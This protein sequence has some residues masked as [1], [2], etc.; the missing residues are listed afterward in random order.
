M[1]SGMI[2][3]MSLNI[4]Y[5]GDGFDPWQRRIGLVK[6]AVLAAS[7]DILALQAVRQEPA[8]YAGIHQA[9]QLA[10]LLP[11]YQT[12]VFQP[13][14]PQPDGSVNGSSILYESGYTFVE[15]GRLSKRIDYAWLNQELA[16]SLRSIAVIA[17]ESA[18]D[19][20]RVSDHAGLQVTLAW[21]AELLLRVL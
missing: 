21:P 1:R 4:N 13:A 14:D 2:R 11:D 3:I 5:Y 6:E 18:P 12:V 8:R 15:E 9:R 16:G 20:L 17:G 19:G 10:S 7:P